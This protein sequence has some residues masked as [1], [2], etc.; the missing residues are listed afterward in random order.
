MYLP[1]ISI[2]VSREICPFIKLLQLL[3]NIK[4]MYETRFTHFHSG[5]G[6]W[7]SGRV[8]EWAKNPVPHPSANRYNLKFSIASCYTTLKSKICFT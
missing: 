4:K 6:E 8:G 5:M 2:G 1:L 7:G 3:T